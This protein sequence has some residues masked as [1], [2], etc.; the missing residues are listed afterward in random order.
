MVIT[1]ASTVD[2]V[3][4]KF[5]Q[6][7]LETVEH[8]DEQTI[9]LDPGSLV[10]VCQFLKAQLQYSFLETVT[11]VD[12]PE[13]TPRFD[14]VYQLLSIEHQCFIRLKVRVGQRREAHPEVPSITSVWAGA[15]WYEREVYDLFGITF[16]GHPDLRRIMMP[17]DW[18]THP[19]RKD[20]PI[21]GFELPEPH[22]GGQVP[23][24]VDPGVGDYYQQS[25]RSSEGRQFNE[26]RAQINPGQEP[27]T[28]PTTEEA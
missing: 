20:Y 21:S 13:R 26:G 16:A 27:G 10:E 14:V 8:R 4:E 19:L 24:N 7:V 22:W 6:G 9:I 23:Y 15:N 12:W 17:E 5:P 18:T 28:L 3:R 11:A 25:L 2:V 1:A